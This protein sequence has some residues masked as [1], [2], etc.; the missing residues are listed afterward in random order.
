MEGGVRK[1]GNSWYYYFDLGTVDG[2]RKKFE[3]VATGATK[4]SEALRILR[5]A[6][7]E[8][9]NSGTIFEPS[10]TSVSDYMKF[11]L[12][13]YVEL[14]LA[15]NTWD[16]YRMVIETHIN[17]AIGNMRLSSISPE[18]LQKFI[19]DK[20]RA[21]FARKTLTIFHSVLNNSLRQAVYPYKL[22]KENPMQYV[23][24]PR[25]ERKK[26]T[27]DDLKVI[28][29]GQV[30]TILDFLGKDNT[31]Y[32]PFLIGF[33]T[34]MRRGEVCALM[35][36]KVDLVEGTIEVDKAMTRK[37]K[38]WVLGPPKNNSS[39][40]TFQIGAS[41][42][43]LLKKHKLQQKK[44][45]LKYGKF[46]QDSNYVCTKE[47]GEFV[48]PYSVKYSCENIQKKL[49]IGFGFHSLRHTHATLLLERGAPIKDVQHRL[50]HA[51]AS[52]T[53]D[54]YLHLT[55]K[56]QNQTMDI[57]EGITSELDSN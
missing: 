34:G 28:T 23:K 46:Y 56:M 16:N 21:K 25:M 41:L 7:T 11:W 45:K 53:I 31:F 54:T 39:F 1:R 17:P 5:N 43:N 10:K 33:H 38:D 13:E 20:H 24:L 19:N 55:E 2:Q 26:V 57:F 29:L 35:W 15:Y 49:S 51:R 52:I 44:N 36:D 4:K 27:K 3:R 37:K 40:R 32:I 6:I 47:N 42:V 9:E 18:V 8:Y 12:R 22:I 14:N 30:Q 48:S 50:G